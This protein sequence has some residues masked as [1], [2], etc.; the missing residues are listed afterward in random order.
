MAQKKDSV[1]R[2]VPATTKDIRFEKKY[3]MSREKSEEPFSKKTFSIK[4]FRE[5]TDKS[6][7]N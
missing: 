5:I 6:Q 3:L 2:K 1:I 4:H 7:K